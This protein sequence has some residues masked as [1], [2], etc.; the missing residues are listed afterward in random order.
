MKKIGLLVMLLGSVF[1]PACQPAP[2]VV[3]VG[4]P[5]PQG[6]PGSGYAEV[7]IQPAV[8]EGRGRGTM[9]CSARGQQG[10]L[11]SLSMGVEKNGNINRLLYYFD[12]AQAGLP[13]NATVISAILIL[14]P[15]P[16]FCSPGR[17]TAHV[18]PVT[19]AWTEDEATWMY[20]DSKGRWDNDGGDFLTGLPMGGFWAEGMNLQTASCVE[21]YLDPTTV[22]GWLNGYPN[23]GML[24][25]ADVEAGLANMVTFLGREYTLNPSKHPQ[26]KLIYK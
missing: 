19:K 13:A 11:P 5:G 9:I 7:V 22:Q 20:A 24:I 14:Y 17:I 18:Y 15:N 4:P 16:T 21:V 3:Q 10:R 6:P 8:G 1:L 23:Y 12:V 2:K 25:K 26:L